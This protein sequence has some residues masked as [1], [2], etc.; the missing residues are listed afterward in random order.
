MATIVATEEIT[1]TCMIIFDKVQFTLSAT[2]EHKT[3]ANISSGC[4]AIL[5][6][7]HNVNVAL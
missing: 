3:P 7:C 5:Q 6:Y 1:L 2:K 4:G